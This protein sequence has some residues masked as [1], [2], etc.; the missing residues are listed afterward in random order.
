[1]KNC[2]TFLS[3]Y[4]YDS[5]H[6]HK[7]SRTK[8]FKRDGKSVWRLALLKIIKSDLVEIMLRDRKIHYSTTFTPN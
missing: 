3:R 8:F 6:N 4:T 5:N 2:K 1:M 7:L